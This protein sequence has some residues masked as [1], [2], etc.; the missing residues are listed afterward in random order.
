MV[1]NEVVTDNKAFKDVDGTSPPWME[2]LNQRGS[3]VNLEVMVECWFKFG[4]L[5]SCK[6]HIQREYANMLISRCMLV[7]VMP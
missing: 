3:T 7:S 1:I 4:G 6:F 2:L 5:M